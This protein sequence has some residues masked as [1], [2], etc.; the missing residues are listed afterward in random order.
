M[1]DGACL[2]QN[3][4]TIVFVEPEGGRFRTVRIPDDM[5]QRLED[6]HVAA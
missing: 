2:L 4:Q 1:R 3:E 5:R 6:Q